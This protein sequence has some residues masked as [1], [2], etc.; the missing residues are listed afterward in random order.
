MDEEKYTI[1]FKGESYINIIEEGENKVGE[2]IETYFKRIKRE[3][4][5]VN[6]IEKIYFIYNGY[7]INKSEYN[8][9]INL[10]IK[11]KKYK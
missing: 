8:K 3:N 11:H 2:L 9:I 1:Q 7:I 10:K 6:N 4:L 5:L